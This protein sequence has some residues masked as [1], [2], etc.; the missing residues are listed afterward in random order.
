MFCLES[1]GFLHGNHCFTLVSWMCF[2][3][4]CN[5]VWACICYRHIYCNATPI[6]CSINLNYEQPSRQN[7]SQWPQMCNSRLEI[8]EIPNTNNISHFVKGTTGMIL[9]HYLKQLILL[10]QFGWWHYYKMTMKVM[11]LLYIL[12]C[13]LRLVQYTLIALTEISNAHKSPLSDVW[14]HLSWSVGSRTNSTLSENS[15]QFFL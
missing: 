9:S 1:S 6:S 13:T 5:L 3:L 15:A 2:Y 7:H 14:I 4:F 12:L 8:S 10:N 11:I